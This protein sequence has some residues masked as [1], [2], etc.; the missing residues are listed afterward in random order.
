MLTQLTRKLHETFPT[1]PIYTEKL[2][3]PSKTNFQVQV[4]NSTII[5]TCN[6]TYLESNLYSLI[7]TVDANLETNSLLDTMKRDLT[8]ALDDYL[9]QGVDFNKVDNTLHCLFT[10]DQ[11]ISTIT[12]SDFLDKLTIQSIVE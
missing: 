9:Y 4:V 12:S 6:N 1:I 2:T 11:T 5:P 8:I 7:Y 3:N 10:L